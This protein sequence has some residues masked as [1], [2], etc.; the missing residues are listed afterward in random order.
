MKADD[1]RGE[2]EVRFEPLQ[3]QAVK[4]VWRGVTNLVTR[5]RGLPVLPRER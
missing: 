3:V 4:L 1:D 2:S 5:L